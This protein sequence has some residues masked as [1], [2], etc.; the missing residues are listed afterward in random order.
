MAPNA[1]PL[2]SMHLQRI[3]NA[4]GGLLPE[5]A[6]VWVQGVAALSYVRTNIVVAS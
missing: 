1:F 4:V 3:R 2:P 5:Q 6:G